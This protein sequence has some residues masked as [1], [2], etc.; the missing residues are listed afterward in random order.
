MLDF[1][2]HFPYSTSPDEATI[3]ALEAAGTPGECVTLSFRVTSTGHVKR[4]R[5]SGG[6]LTAPH[7]G[8]IPAEAL[9][10]FVVKQWTQAGLGL[11]RSEP[12]QVGELLLKE[13]TVPLKDGYKRRWKKWSDLFNPVYTY[14]PPAVRLTGDACT[15][16]KAGESKQIFIRLTLPDDSPSGTY[17]GVITVTAGEAIYSLKLAVRVYP[18]TLLPARQ[19]LFLWYKG[20][21]GPLR[22]PQFHVPESL[23]QAQLQDIYNHGFRSVALGET[24]PRKAQR[25]IEIAETV[26]FA[27]NVVFQWPFPR[28]MKTLTFKQVTPAVYVSDEIDAQ[29]DE[30]EIQA[31]IQHVQKARKQSLLTMCSVLSAPFAQRL[32]DDKDI[33][34]APDIMSFYLPSTLDYFSLHANFTGT[35]RKKVL[36]YWMIHMEKPNLNRVLCGVY[37]WKSR[38]DGI[39]PYCYQHLPKHPYSPYNDFDLWEP[40]M[41]VNEEGQPLRDH[42]AVYPAKEGV[43][44]TLQW[45]GAREGITDL[46]YLT[47]LDHW[48]SEA[49]ERE[50]TAPALG[51]IEQ[52]VASFLSRIDLQAIEILSKTNPEPYPGIN[53]EEYHQFRLF[54]A[55]SILSLINLLD[56]KPTVMAS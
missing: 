35:R 28:K 55:N 26:G 51:E 13:D 2:A 27:H 12:V 49:R 37:L 39:A 4:I 40:R 24:Y 56:P 33:G 25:A 50:I 11:Y 30:A 17:H 48:L 47:T 34:Y 29:E 19:E 43:I 32:L 3:T 36:Y 10:L 46:R 41:S 18:F 8:R 20:T 1:Y 53:A 38:A 31:H 23:F 15:T 44:P 42:L 9:A 45:E 22:S 7:G 6:A 5:F 54:L 14:Q 21:L 16:L 52:G